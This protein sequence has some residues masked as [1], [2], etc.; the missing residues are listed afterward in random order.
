MLCLVLSNEPPGIP[1]P[2][3]PRQSSLSSEGGEVVALF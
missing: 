1:G 3:A 2:N